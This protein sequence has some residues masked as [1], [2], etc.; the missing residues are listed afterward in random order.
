M[1]STATVGWS[2]LAGVMRHAVRFLWP[3][4]CAQCGTALADDPV[5]SFCR[6]CWRTIT[7]LSGARCARC[8]RPFGSSAATSHS[9]EH[10]CQS[11]LLRPPSYTRAW[12]LYPYIPPLQNAIHLLKYRRSVALTPALGRLIID[13]WPA[14]EPVDRIMPVPLHPRRLREREFN[15]SLLL[16]DWVARRWRI[17][18]SFANLIRLVPSTPQTTLSR[19]QRLKNLRGAFAVRRPDAVR[20][21]RILLIDDVWTTGA[22]MNECAKTLRKAGS[23]P[24]FALTVARTMEASAIPDRVRAAHAGSD[25]PPFGAF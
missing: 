9:P 8:D 5:A 15:Q 1:L 4:A 10:L 3:A 11:C 22:T 6:A 23:G 18:V 24:V 25:C 21:H 2:D 17:P 13:A 14:M 12:T 7:P 20:N 16:A 19:K